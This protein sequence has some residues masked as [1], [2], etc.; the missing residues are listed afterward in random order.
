MARTPRTNPISYL[1]LGLAGVAH[2]PGTN[3][4]RGRQCREAAVHV[5]QHHPRMHHAGSTS[6]MLSVNVHL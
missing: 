4:T 1:V 6:R 5:M 3:S 2:A